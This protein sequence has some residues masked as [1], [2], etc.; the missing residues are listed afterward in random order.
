MCVAYFVPF[1]FG[2]AAPLLPHRKPI[3]SKSDTAS[4]RLAEGGEPILVSPLLERKDQAEG[5]LL[6]L[7]CFGSILAHHHLHGNHGSH[8][9]DMQGNGSFIGTGSLIGDGAFEG[10][11]DFTGTG[12]FVG[13]GECSGRNITSLPA[14]SAVTTIDPVA[15]AAAP[16]AGAMHFPVTL[17]QPPPSIHIP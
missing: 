12:T 11:G 14:G 17:G 15:V 6:L 2:Q 16:Q 3:G 4:L 13:V 5:A 10:N 8:L 7:W 1:R 9:S